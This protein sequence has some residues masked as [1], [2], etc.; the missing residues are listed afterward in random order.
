MSRNVSILSLVAAMVVLIVLGVVT[1]AFAEQDN[2][3][4]LGQDKVTLCHK[5]KK[6]LTVGAPAQEAHLRHGDSPG[7]CP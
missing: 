6:T 4:G 7:A 5:G 3:G 1:V 2:E